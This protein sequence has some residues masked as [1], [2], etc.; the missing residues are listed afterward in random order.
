METLMQDQDLLFYYSHENCPARATALPVIAWLC[1]KHGMDYDGYFCVRPSVA[2]IG[3]AMPFTG[4]KHDAQFY[5]LA[6]FYRHIHF[7][8][9]TEEEP[10]QF[11]RFLSGRSNATI[12]KESSNN[13]IDFYVALF[14][15]FDESF[16]PQAVVFPSDAFEFPNEAVDFGE[17]RIPGKSR[18]DTFCYPETFF[19]NALAIH[20]ELSQVQLTRL[21][22]L[23]VKEIK[24]IFCSDRALKRYA[25]LG[26][27][28]EVIDSIQKDD[29]YTTIT[30]RIAERWLDNANGMAMGNDPVTLR[31]SPK[32]LRE[33][34]LTI[35]AVNFMDTAIDTL[36]RF[37]DKIGN[38]LVWGSQIYNDLIISD[39]SKHDIVLSLV[40]DVEVGIT[41]K[42]KVRLPS[43]WLR[44]SPAP[45]DQEY[46]KDHLKSRIEM[47][48]IP[49]CFMHYASDLGHL[50]V[51]E[52]LLD[53]HSIDDF[54]SGI[55]FPSSW[56][57]YA[58]EQLEQ[59]YI[60]SE[61]GG[62]FP[63]C[64]PLVSS[65]GIGVATEAA[66]YLSPEA[67][68]KNLRKAKEFI[69]MRAGERHIPIGHYSYQDACPY[70]KHN[71]AEPQFD[72]LVKA[73]FD[74]AISYKNEGNPPEIIYKDGQFIALNQQSTHWSFDPL[75]DLRSWENK[76]IQSKR[77]GWIIIGLDAPFWGMVPCYFG[78]ASKGLSLK[79][80]QEAMSYAKS[81][82]HS[83]KLFPAKP[84]EVARYARLLYEKY[85]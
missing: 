48:H 2:D 32:Y 61:M 70:Y 36:G 49:V 15:F 7:F 25:D 74:Y 52:R 55:A 78:I 47:G 24:A 41:I 58:E 60:S 39:A 65:A 18:L 85:Y 56:W 23:G 84:H 16:P 35:G 9:L 53:L 76:L 3:D 42:N 44:K 31:W 4:N 72:V 81:G 75:T 37:T 46:S 64:E 71:T 5:Y 79:D 59:L 12:V 34:I 27:K 26:F 54:R 77:R 66:G 30:S 50:P 45:W 51:L 83:G 57:E 68:L 62:V 8:A 82:G 22:A 29:N 69:K 38:K 13:L 43:L 21:R 1:E 63:A 80:L 20:E 73:G 19:R 14:K 17:F 10:V 33:R 40:H 67:Y 6:N 28:V 11:E